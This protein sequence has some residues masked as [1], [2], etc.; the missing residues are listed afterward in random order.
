MGNRVL[1][2]M[3]ALLLMIV[4]AIGQTPDGAKAKT[5]AVD[6]KWT[7][8]R[9]SDG[10]LDLQGNWSIATLT[11]LE[12]PS[13]LAGKP[14]FTAKEAVEYEKELL[15]N[16]N[17]DRR[18]GGAEVDLARSYNNSWYD[19]GTKVVKSRKTSLVIDPPDGRIPD[20]TPQ[21]K[22]RV[23]ALIAARR[24]RGREPADSWIDRSLMERCITAGAPRLPGPYNNNLQ[25]VQ[26]PE[27][28]AILYETIHEVRIIPMD[29][30]PHIDKNIR[31]WLGDSR[32]RWDGNTLVVDTTNFTDDELVFNTSSCCNGAS[33]N[34]HIVERFARIDADTIDYQFTVDDPST[35]IRPWT[36]AIPMNKTE[37]PIYEYA[38][39]EGNYG[40]AGILSGAR[41][42]E[43]AAQ[44]A[45]KR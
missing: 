3:S 44:A 18:D 13:Q 2:A 31:R 26:T 8:P 39:H 11:P 4:A 30:R 16:N 12:R 20:F 5:A 33:A 15:E 35:Y 6:Q 34:L 29:G 45:R 37:G 17:K 36:V 27:Y 42:Q 24:R 23:N 1:A 19:S 38:C 7:P 41:A 22:L 21:A 43:R 9:S 32:G 14:S 25:I 40:L 28:V 10:H